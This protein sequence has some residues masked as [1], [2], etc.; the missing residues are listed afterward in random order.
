MTDKKSHFCLFHSRNFQRLDR[1]EQSLVETH[2][3]SNYV[4][5]MNQLYLCEWYHL[6][7]VVLINQLVQTGSYQSSFLCVL[8]VNHFLVALLDAACH[9][10]PNNISFNWSI[11]ELVLLSVRE[12][13]AANYRH[14]IQTV[15]CNREQ[16][17]IPLNELLSRLKVLIRVILWSLILK[18]RR[19]LDWGCLLFRLSF[20]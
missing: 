20:R 17:E 3:C 13:V 2:E 7:E 9:V 19:R 16:D 8:L 15:E 4:L 5:I 10:S 14:L 12:L 18:E 6:L 11:K 1:G